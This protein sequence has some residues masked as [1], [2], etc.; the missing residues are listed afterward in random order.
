MI[1]GLSQFVCLVTAVGK[2]AN[3]R[4]QPNTCGHCKETRKGIPGFMKTVKDRPVASSIFAY[5]K[6]ITRVSF[7]P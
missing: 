1:V 6:D 5:K 2:R 7:K 3:Y 4:L